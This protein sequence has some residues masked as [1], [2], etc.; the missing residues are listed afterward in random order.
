MTERA[1]KAPQT[2]EDTVKLLEASLVLVRLDAVARYESWLAKQP[3]AADDTSLAKLQAE[4]NAAQ[5]AEAQWLE[6]GRLTA[7]KRDD[8][9]CAECGSYDVH[10]FEC[11]Q[12]P[13]T[14]CDEVH[15]VC[16]GA[17]DAEVES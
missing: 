13:A 5:R 4:I 11:D 2:A 15:C 14:C 1:R 7:A 10:A 9:P 8:E 17:D 3:K 16:G 6:A 12:R